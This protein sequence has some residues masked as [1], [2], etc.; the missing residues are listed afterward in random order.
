ME[1]IKKIMKNQN[2]GIPIKMIKNINSTRKF[3]MNSY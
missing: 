3:K 2:K 1:E